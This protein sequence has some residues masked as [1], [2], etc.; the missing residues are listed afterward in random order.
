M[1]Q[2]LD[3]NYIKKQRHKNTHDRKYINMYINTVFGNEITDVFLSILAV[4][5]IACNMGFHI[6]K[7]FEYKNK[8]KYL[9]VY[10]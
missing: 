7:L 10:R 8:T 1:I 9:K 2:T 6:N 4:F 5:Q 3:Y